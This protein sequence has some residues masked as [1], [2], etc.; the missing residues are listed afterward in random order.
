MKILF[1]TNVILDVM[2]LRDPFLRAATSLLAEVERKNIEGFVCSTTV[3]TIYYLVSKTKGS[4]EAKKQVENLLRLFNVTHV[5]KRELE[6]ALYSDILDYEDAV[7][8]E[9]ALGENLN[10]IVTG[11]TKDFRNSKLTVFN[12]EELLKIVKSSLNGQ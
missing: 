3:T 11:N 9:S 1:D 10:G 12:P 8:H 5:E 6:S 2:L 4:K 7:L